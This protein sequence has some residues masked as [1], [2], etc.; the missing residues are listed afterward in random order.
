M[1]I[2]G[3]Q[4]DKKNTVYLEFILYPNASDPGR[5][6]IQYSFFILPKTLVTVQSRTEAV[7]I[8]GGI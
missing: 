2:V 1:P 8:D 3:W 5:R 6:A 4:I 7:D